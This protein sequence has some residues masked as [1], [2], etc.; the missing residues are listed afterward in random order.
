MKHEPGHFV[1]FLLATFAL[2]KSDVGTFSSSA[3]NPE[4]KT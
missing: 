3:V 2:R 4:N 1:V